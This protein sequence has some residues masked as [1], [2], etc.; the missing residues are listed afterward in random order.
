V[1]DR[2]PAPRREAEVRRTNNKGKATQLGPAELQELPFEIELRP[3][4][5]PAVDGWNDLVKELWE[6]LKVDPA[7]AWMTSA[8]WGLTRIVFQI[9]SD[10]LGSTDEVGHPIPVNGATQTAIL[11]HMATI[12][13]TEHARLRM[14]KEITLFP[15]EPIDTEGNVIDINTAR[16]QEVQ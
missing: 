12:G 5:L 7:R 10:A 3:D 9:L 8:D 4:P 11:K 1:G 2:G 14:Q 6:D 15:R 13:V 16:Q